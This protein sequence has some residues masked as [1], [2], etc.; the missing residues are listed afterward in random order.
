MELDLGTFWPLQRC[1]YHS[2]QDCQL[3][4]L[5]EIDFPTKDRLMKAVLWT[6]VPPGLHR[7]FALLTLIALIRSHDVVNTVTRLH[8]SCEAYS[9][10]LPAISSSPSAMGLLHEERQLAP[11]TSLYYRTQEPHNDDSSVELSTIQPTKPHPKS[12]DLTFKA[13]HSTSFPTA[14]T[15]TWEEKGR[16]TAGAH[17]LH[18]QDRPKTRAHSHAEYSIHNSK[19]KENLSASHRRV[20]RL[21]QLSLLSCRRCRTGKETKTHA[22]VS[23]F[24]GGVRWG[25]ELLH[26]KIGLRLRD[27]RCM[28]RLHLR[29]CG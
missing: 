24:G 12:R 3:A 21:L 14:S 16:K 23:R 6:L 2:I 20:D 4:F 7:S 19:L 17:L 9:I 10:A 26:L 8:Q 29:R 1:T 25:W 18:S 27:T 15:T 5:N 22:S 11:H 13:Q 28:Q